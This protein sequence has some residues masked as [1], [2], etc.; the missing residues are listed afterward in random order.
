MVAKGIAVLTGL[1]SIPLTIKYLGDER[2]GMW[3]TA[4]SIVAMLGFA[5][6]G[7][8][9][10]LLNSV[11]EADGKDDQ[12]QA[13]VA[14]SSAFGAL[15][16][17][18][19]V[20][21]SV[22]LA[23]YAYLPWARLFNVN[24]AKA[25]SEAGPVLAVF[26]LTFALG[27]PFGSV[28]RVQMGLQDGYWAQLANIAGSLLGLAGLVLAL[29]LRAGLPWLILAIT[30]APVIVSAVNGL[31]YFVARRPSLRPRL[32]RMKWGAARK[33]L[34]TGLMFVVLPS[35]STR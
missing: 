24:S 20:I 27:L 26:V 29:R 2:Y 21:L 4:S 33:L 3:M 23:A 35:P 31:L 25:M 17:L 7:L 10:G 13:A 9:N 8:A 34:S 30:G 16:I 22:F 6:L 18:G 15:A 11:S 5:D 28:Q 12:E 14:I 19:L 1:V 32:T